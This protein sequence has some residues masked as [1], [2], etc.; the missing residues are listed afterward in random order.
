MRIQGRG[1]AGEDDVL[2]ESG[3]VWCVVSGKTHA[4]TDI[5]LLFFF[6]SERRGSL[7][8]NRRI[9]V[10]VFVLVLVNTFGLCT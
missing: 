5:A 10:L 1:H 7:A 8:Q 4:T 2:G 6:F 3:G 9:F